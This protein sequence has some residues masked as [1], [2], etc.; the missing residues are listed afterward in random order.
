MVRGISP[1]NPIW[2]LALSGSP[3][4]A[5]WGR[6]P[7]VS[8]AEPVANLAK[9]FMAGLDAGDKFIG[10]RSV[11]SQLQDIAGTPGSA[12]SQLLGLG[13]SGGPYGGTGT[14]N[15]ANATNYS[16]SVPTFSQGGAGSAPKQVPSSANW[17]AE[18]RQA[19]IEEATAAGYNPEDLATVM[20]YETAGSMDPWKA[21]P[22]T[23]WGQHRGLI[24]WGEPQRQQYGVT[25][26][27]S[28]RDQVKASIRYLQDRGL[29]PGMGMLEM[30]SAIN[31]GGIGPEYYRRSDTAAGG[32][33][34]TV[35]DKVQNQMGA[36]RKRVQAWFG[37]DAGMP[38]PGAVAAPAPSPQQVA[39]TQASQPVP[40]DRP[41]SVLQ[42]AQ[43]VLSRPDTFDPRTVQWAQGVVGNQQTQQPA[44]AP[45]LAPSPND[46]EIA[47]Q[48]T[49][50]Q[51]ATLQASQNPQRPPTFMGLPTQ[52]PG[53]NVNPAAPALAGG[54]GDDILMGGTGDRGPVVAPQPAAPAP[55]QAPAPMPPGAGA[56]P[57]PAPSYRAP[58]RTASDGLDPRLV[59]ALGTAVAS[60]DANSI[61]AVQSLL[62]A[63][64]RG[65]RGNISLETL[66]DGS[67]VLV[68]A[69][70]G[71][72]S[73]YSAG[74]GSDPKDIELREV[75]S[76]LVEYNKRNGQWRVLPV[77]G[78]QGYR[79][80]TPEERTTYNVR[81]GQPA[82]MGPDGKP[83]F[84]PAGTSV[85]VTNTPENKGAT[86]AAEKQ[87]E[88]LDKTVGGY[89]AARDQASASLP[90]LQQLREI[91][92]RTGPQGFAA[93]LKTQYGPI[94]EGLGFDVPGLS[95]AQTVQAIIE[96]LAPR[97]RVEGSGS[98][99]DAEY[100][101][102]LRSLPTLLH[103][104]ETRNNLLSVL[105]LQNQTDIARGELADKYDMGEIEL[106]DVIAGNRAL[107]K[108][109]REGWQAFRDKN[110]REM[111]IG[112]NEANKREAVEG[113][114]DQKRRREGQQAAAPVDR[115]SQLRA[116][117]IPVNAAGEVEAVS[118]EAAN[119]LRLQRGDRVRITA[120]PNKGRLMEMK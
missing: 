25:E 58:I 109:A 5:S 104:P 50:N 6:G 26:N 71:E 72:V 94:L 73:P 69:A 7:Q 51:V 49:Q 55:A 85:S 9:N 10:R 111:A 107:T 39:T 29:R 105:E 11:G 62:Q 112:I 102:F 18:N 48:V 54:G 44:A 96:Q 45:Q 30:Y 120:G 40:A 92:N 57:R 89:A 1:V 118:E 115:V 82:Y 14:D 20:S 47:S 27:T 19:I 2:Q 110:A 101:G 23:K 59:R 46:R 52:A 86:K 60:G 83:N 32:A 119:N 117:G 36:H 17:N 53:G 4:D 43:D 8:F 84:G 74:T 70:T 35:A 68:D 22:T 31:A 106:K 61:A 38:A 41:A 99:S 33:P 37:Q 90:Q 34:G 76:Q 3:V 100:K 63:G 67:T 95:D 78:G 103:N 28:F 21:G 91:F 88:R 87:A 113:R 56:A 97:Q 108:Q 66:P 15:I 42:Q 77:G 16:R 116:A 65:S 81:E 64:Q 98:Q 93:E 24:Q 13:A 114:W 79:P 80:M 75:N 12:A